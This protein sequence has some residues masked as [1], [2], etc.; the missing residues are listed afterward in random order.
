MTNPSV[1]VAA[2]A[3]AAAATAL[4]AAA[5]AQTI[6]AFNGKVFATVESAERVTLMD[7]TEFDITVTD[8]TRLMCGSAQMTPAEFANVM[9][10]H[11]A[12]H[13][14]DDRTILDSTGGELGRRT[15][16]DI[17]FELAGSVPS[18]AN[19]SFQLAEQYIES[20]FSDPITIRIQV[21]F[22][23]LGGGVLGA[24]G[25]SQLN[26]PYDTWRDFMIDD[27]DGD[28]ILQALLPD[29]TLPVRYNG[30]T[31]TVTEEGTVKCSRAQVKA[32]QILDQNVVD[33]TMTYNNQFNWDF[34]PRN[35]TSFSQFSL[36]DTIIHE[37]GHAM[38]F[39]SAVDFGTGTESE[40]MDTI[41]FVTSGGFD[42]QS[43]AAFTTTPRTVDFNNPNSQHSLDVITAEYRAEDGNP[44][45][46]SH[47]R[48]QSNNIGI[49]DAA[50]AN[51][52]T[53]VNRQ[54]FGYYTQADLDVFDY[55][56]YDRADC[57]A[58]AIDTQPVGQQACTFD[59]VVLTV[60]APT[61]VEFQWL[62]NGNPITDG[63]FFSGTQTDTLTINSISA[64]S[65]GAFAVQV[66]NAE[67]CTTLSQSVNV[68]VSD[69]PTISDQPD[70]LTL[71]EGQTAV[72]SAT[73]SGAFGFQW[74]KD[75]TPLGNGGNIS[76]AFTD[77][78]TITNVTDADEA[79]Y[80]LV[81]STLG[82]C[83]SVSNAATL[84]VNTAGPMPCN[85]ADLAEPFE[86]LDLTDI[87]AFIAAFV[88]Q[89]P[90]ADIAVPFGV[91][92][93]SDIDAFIAAFLGGCP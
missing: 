28:D 9:Q 60:S 41:R 53:F 57:E 18:A 13:D 58:P 52:E 82:D 79:D 47:F 91:I 48:E 20:F 51:G 89:D 92:D 46:G 66:T 16:I 55:L 84:T 25:S 8:R 38:G 22:A 49:M 75:G 15:G 30:S 19:I 74:E 59:N 21:S 77:T 76:G 6:T 2:A 72:F 83:D 50:G 31:T 7:G 80:T 45:Q 23:N 12:A 26:L 78:L 33:A 36:V 85:A 68:T 3:A 1:L 29:N 63:F 67:D 11:E 5:S 43:L 71:D 64:P 81:A 87:D 65:A 61:A 32:A 14:V 10:L 24:T 4:G 35:G 34:D 44:F 27:A 39:T 56:G 88:A 37:V 17:Q 62:Q 42:P 69:R 90:A 93:L 40:A 70:S 86:V 54:P 73:V